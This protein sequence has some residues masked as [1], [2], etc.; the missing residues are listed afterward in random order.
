L[1]DEP[2]THLHPQAQE[3]LKDELIK[4]TRNE[5]NNIVFFAT[6]SNHM[7]DKDHIERCFRL[8]KQANRKTKLDKIKLGKTS[9]PEVNYEV[10]GIPSSDYHNEL[11]G[12]LEDIEKS[13]LDSLP[14]TKK[15]K[16]K[17]TKATDNVS[18]ATY[19]RHSIHHTENTTNAKFTAG[20]LAESIKTLRGLK[21]GNNKK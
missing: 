18:L 4:I 11:Y 15:W 9:Y 2:E 5:E 17:K 6:H 7:I 3:Y 21:Y 13:K 14:K 10:F 20:E 12:Y 8:S 16:N 19:I 1:L